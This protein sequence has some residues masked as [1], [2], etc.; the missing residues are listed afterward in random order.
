TDKFDAKELEKD[1]ITYIWNFGNRKKKETSTP[2]ITYT[3]TTAGDYRLSV[4]A[5]DSHGDSTTSDAVGLYAGNETP[6]VNIQ[7][8][9]PNES[10]YLPGVPVNYSVAVMD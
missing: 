5:K 1:N 4:T 8:I 10:F 6:V 9:S 7:L 3:Y 2:Q